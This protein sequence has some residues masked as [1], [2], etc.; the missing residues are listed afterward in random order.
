[1]RICRA[2]VAADSAPKAMKRR[3]ADR[4]TKPVIDRAIAQPAVERLPSPDHAE[5]IV[6]YPVELPVVVFVLSGHTDTLSATTDNRAS[7]LMDGSGHAVAPGRERLASKRSSS[8]Y[9]NVSS[10]H[11]LRWRTR[12]NAHSHRKNVGECAFAFLRNAVNAH[13]ARLAGRRPRA[14]QAG[15]KRP[16]IAVHPPSTNKTLPVT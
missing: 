13:L 1:M 6:E 11:S 16:S 4:G 3:I 15:V 2:C 10:S 8:L 5:L 9:C 14:F 7:C 12:P